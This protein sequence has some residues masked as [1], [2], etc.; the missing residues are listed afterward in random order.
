M[1]QNT[2]KNVAK[3]PL[4]VLISFQFGQLVWNMLIY[5]FS[6]QMQYYYENVV[7]LNLGLYTIGFVIYTI[8]N[9]FNDPL[10]GYLSDR[11]KRWT[12]KWGKRFPLILIFG[13]TWSISFIF[14]F[15][16][17]PAVIIGQLGTFV[18]LLITICIF[19]TLGSGWSVNH[20]ALFADKFKDYKQRKQ[21]GQFF[22][23]LATV[24]LMIGAIIPSIIVPIFGDGLGYLMMG[25]FLGIIGIIFTLASIPGIKESKELRE[26]RL[27]LDEQ[28][29]SSFFSGLKVVLRHKNFVVYLVFGLLYQ[30]F[31]YVGVA[32][33]AF[34]V[35]DV[36][37]LPKTSE[38][39]LMLGLIVA[40]PLTAPL[41]YKLSL[42]VGAKKVLTIG[43]LLMGLGLFPF[44]FIPSGSNGLLYSL[45]AIVI[46]GIGGGGR[47]M[48]DFPIWG[49]IM[50]ESYKLY[51]QKREGLYQGIVTFF[52]RLAIAAQVIIFF[53]VHTLSG[54][55]PNATIQSTSALLGLRIQLGL[56]PMI[57]MLISSAIFWKFYD[58]T[59][60]KLE[61][62]NA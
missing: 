41:W 44:L 55:D 47:L 43:N 16:A 21:S 20:Y 60:D 7:L 12:I 59:P 1:I 14:V 13:L 52:I 30:I 38:M 22:A 17:P 15:S 24:G 57:I 50:D 34:W 27:L 39:I 42:K 61:K 18:W 53:L 32:S 48:A 56:I 45:L 8:W 25:L 6:A 10:V 51:G 9:M 28:S 26:E 5:T 49:D 2:V 29:Q 36:L 31:Y 54:Y 37:L 3:Y 46:V 19:D 40:Q 62:M 33:I 4:S 58:L 23:I 35:A 11:T